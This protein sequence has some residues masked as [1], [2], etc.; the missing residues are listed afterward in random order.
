[1]ANNLKDIYVGVNSKDPNRNENDLYRTP[2]IATY[3]LNK[4]A[5]LPHYIIEPCAGYG[6]IS[7]ELIRCGHDVV[8]YDLH[9]YET[10]SLT[11]IHT[12]YDVLELEPHG[13]HFG[14]VTNPPYNN[15]LPYKI[16]LKALEE[17][18]Y[19]ALLVRLTFLEGIRRKKIFDRIKPTQIIFFS[20]RIKFDN[21][22]REPIEMCDQIGGMIAYCWV[23][24]DQRLKN[25]HTD[26]KWVCMKD[27]YEEW[28]SHYDKTLDT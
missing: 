1:M 2:P 28:R 22:H 20:D 23:I 11:Y 13:R 18:D 19:V 5:D 12:P 24:F 25:Q 26:C 27:E 6:N 7:A 16:T 9:S 4:Y 8:S 21:A 15:N 17:Y 10:E 14:F 3:I